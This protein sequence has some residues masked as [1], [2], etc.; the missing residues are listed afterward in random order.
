MMFG[1]ITPP[2]GRTDRDIRNEILDMFALE[3]V[4][5]PST[6]PGIRA[7]T[8][9]VLEA[10]KFVKKLRDFVVP[11]SGSIILNDDPKA[12]QNVN[13]IIEYIRLMSAGLDS[14]MESWKN[15]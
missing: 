4:N 12:V 10:K 6:P 1:N 15:E 13:D 7:Y 3:L 14:F 9:I 5:D 11:A 2:T 8:E